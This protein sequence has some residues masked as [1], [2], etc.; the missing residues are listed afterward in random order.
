VINAGLLGQNRFI[1]RLSSSIAST[2]AQRVSIGINEAS[3]QF[4]GITQRA[5]SDATRSRGCVAFRTN[6]PHFSANVPSGDRAHSLRRTKERFEPRTTSER[7]TRHR[8]EERTKERE[9]TEI[10]PPGTTERDG[11]AGLQK[12]GATSGI[13]K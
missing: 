6:E 5:D 2:R 12:A 9:S 11:N 10:R 1:D 13:E 4:H 7:F 8:E 3:V